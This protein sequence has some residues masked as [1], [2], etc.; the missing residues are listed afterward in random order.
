MHEAAQGETAGE[1]ATA[2]GILRGPEYGC[3]GL[4]MVPKRDP[5]IRNDLLH[6][7]TAILSDYLS[8]FP[9][10]PKASYAP[11]G[12]YPEHIAECIISALEE[13]GWH[14]VKE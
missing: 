11:E 7:M 1:L 6:D 10:Q 8:S 2:Q 5:Q 3:E 13:K 14:G 12:L 4:S 9:H